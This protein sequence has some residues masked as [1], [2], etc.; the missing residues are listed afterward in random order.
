MYAAEN[1]TSPLRLRDIFCLSLASSGPFFIPNALLI[2]GLN[3]PAEYCAI[4]SIELNINLGKGVV[5]AVKP[6]R[7]RKLDTSAN[8]GTSGALAYVTSNALRVESSIS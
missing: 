1:P 4:S 5:T 7:V 8:K 2:A 6:V 3:A